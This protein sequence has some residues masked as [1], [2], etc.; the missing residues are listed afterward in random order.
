MMTKKTC[1]Q[2]VLK[3]NVGQVEIT[4]V[5]ERIYEYENRE[6]EIKTLVTSISN[7]GQKQPVNVVDYN[8]KLVII[9]GVLRYKAI[10]KIEGINTI[11]VLVQPDVITNEDDLL[12]LIIHNQLHKEKTKN[13]KLNEVKIILR[14]DEED[15]NPKRDRE[16]RIKLVEGKLGKG[17]KKN[18]VLTFEKLLHWVEENGNVYDLA[19]RVLMGDVSI[20][21]VGFFLKTLE[22]SDYGLKNE[23]EAL[24]LKLFLLGN[25]NEIQVNNLILVYNGKKNE[26]FTNFNLGGLKHSDYQIIVG[27]CKKTKLP[28]STKIDLVM[29]SIPYYQQI[30]YGKVEDGDLVKYEIGWEKKPE[31]YVKNVCETFSLNYDNINESGVVVINVNESY[32]NGECVGVV[33]MIIVEMKRLG[34]K[35][36]QTTCWFKKDE[37]PQPNNIKRLKTNFEYCLIFTKTS[38]YYFNPIKIK[39]DKKK[40]RITKGCKEQ[41]RTE[42]TYYISNIYDTLTGFMEE[43][44]MMDVIRINQNTERGKREFETNF[45]GD[46]PSLLPAFFTLI[47][48]PVG[49]VCWDPYGGN[50]GSSIVLQLGRKLVIN[51]L[52]PKNVKIIVKAIEKNLTEKDQEGINRMNEQLWGEENFEQEFELFETEEIETFEDVPQHDVVERILMA[53]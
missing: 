51:E 9:D 40:C 39:N 42:P 17:W 29:T 10:C 44:E 48:T 26:P 46:Y 25:I 24:I 8:G 5:M 6:N 20:N 45:F 47:F 1:T 33:P 53:A 13:E 27:D 11:N 12:D 30:E 4:P 31:D 34:Y 43:Q 38:G 16:T 2:G 32:K 37:K 52:Y 41:G 18:N 23:E 50:G 3:L 49:G 7:E 14:I 21:K 15:K 19:G 35:Y 28:V 22:R 36:I